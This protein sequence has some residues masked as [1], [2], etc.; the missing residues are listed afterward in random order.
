MNQPGLRQVHYGTY[1]END[2]PGNFLYGRPTGESEHVEA[3]VKAQ[4]LAGLA[5]YHND[6]KESKY[7][8]H[9]REPLGKTYL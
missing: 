5:D 7:Q 2:R 4:N 1:G 3:L 9:Q 8:S 6:L